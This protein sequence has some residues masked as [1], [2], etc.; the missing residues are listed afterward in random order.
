LGIVPDGRIASV[1]RNGFGV[2][3]GIKEMETIVDS[4]K[5]VEVIV[6]SLIGVVPDIFSLVEAVERAYEGVTSGCAGTI[7]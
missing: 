2:L 3:K 1:I 7:L 4:I 5:E 6:D